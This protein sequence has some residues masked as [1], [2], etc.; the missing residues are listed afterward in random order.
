[1]MT[2]ASERKQK[3]ELSALSQYIR[4]G[5]NV[6]GPSGIHQLPKKKRK[7]RAKKS[8]RLVMSD[9]CFLQHNRTSVSQ[10]YFSFSINCLNFTICFSCID[11]I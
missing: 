9:Q 6:K 3:P 5:G 8:L 4:V 10:F 2:K 7:R 1:M 11:W